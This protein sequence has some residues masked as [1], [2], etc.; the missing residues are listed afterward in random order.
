MLRVLL[1]AAALA[2]ADLAAAD[3][4]TD[5]LLYC[6]GCHLRNGEAVPE[7]NVPSLHELGPL[8]ASEGGRDYI[9]RVPGVSQTP[10]SN[11]KL[12]AVLN[13]VM[14]EFNANALPA[15]YRPFTAEEVGKARVNVLPDPKAHRAR[16]LSGK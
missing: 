8:L 6:R 5:Y 15:D 3:P 9:I 11:E 4:K 16:I 7:A 13:W 1:L 2:A 12:A 10:M 14:Q